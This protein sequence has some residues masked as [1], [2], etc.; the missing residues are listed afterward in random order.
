MTLKAML[1]A[2]AS[3]LAL[4]Y[5]GPAQAATV[6]Y[7]TIVHSGDEPPPGIFGA[8]V[9]FGAPS[10]RGGSTVF[11]WAASQDP[12][13]LSAGGVF[14]SRGLG[15]ETVILAGDLS[16][17][18]NGN[19]VNGFLRP[20]QINDSVVLEG[21][22]TRSGGNEDDIIYRIRGNAFV[23][24]A[25]A[26]DAAPGTEGTTFTKFGNGFSIGGETIAFT[27]TTTA[28]PARLN[29]TGT[30]F[31]PTN[32]FGI[33]RNSGSGVE[34]VAF[35]GD[36]APGTGGE[37]F[38]D[39]GAP[40]VGDTGTTAFRTLTGEPIP[41]DL[42][43]AIF[44]DDGTGLDL[45][46]REGD[47]APGT[48]GASFLEFQDPVQNGGTTVFR[49]QTTEETG[50]TNDRGIFRDD[51]AGVELVAFEGDVAP[52]TSGET[53]RSFSDPVQSGD[54][55]AFI[56]TTG[57]SNRRGVFRD[58][59]NGLELVA[60]T[61][62][63]A[64]GTSGVFSNIGG[65]RVSNTGRTVFEGVLE[66]RRR[67]LFTTDDDGGLIPLLVAG[68]LLTIGQGDARTVDHFLFD[69]S[70]GVDGDTFAFVA[71][72]TDG[73]SG[74]FTAELTP[75]NANDVSAVPVPAALPLLA[76]ALVGLGLVSRRRK[77]QG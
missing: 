2:G 25:V 22:L 45:V 46:V 50:T 68:Q 60:S 29:D 27:A 28:E 35:Q 33:F 7:Q 64:P 26:G 4:A 3:A 76:T 48:D 42:N 38:R 70:R 54:T 74:V 34:L 73:S 31:F 14:R 12:G 77:R 43:A 71:G 16:N 10:Q 62:D 44:R 63:T 65:F 47:A 32:D 21:T 15:V 49:A 8:F 58:S 1:I 56:G 40:T 24:V 61:G 51:G 75:G 6:N 72:F 66:S 23:A 52:G 59:G 17:Q 53:F 5:A 55:T 36:A 67:G 19:S 18:I 39:F 37:V 13:V 11:D 57:E 30:I 41:T 20:E 69:F 9:E